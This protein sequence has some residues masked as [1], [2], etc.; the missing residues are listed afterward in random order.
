MI[1][2]Y[3]NKQTTDMNYFELYYL[4]NPPTEDNTIYHDKNGKVITKKEFEI[5]Q[6]TLKQNNNSLYNNKA[7]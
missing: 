7:K 2:L 3:Y 6:K 5:L 1:I 4:T